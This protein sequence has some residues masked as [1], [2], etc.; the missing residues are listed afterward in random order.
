VRAL[1]VA[2]GF[3][4][5]ATPAASA[6]LH[7]K[8]AYVHAKK[9]VIVSL[10]SPV[11]QPIAVSETGPPHWSGDGRLLSIGGYVVGR[12][13]LPAA[14]LVWAPTGERAAYVT[15]QGGAGVWTPGSGRR[16]V[17]ANGWGAQSAAW[18]N[19]GSLAL[20]RAVCRAACGRPSHREVWVWRRGSLRRIVG[21]LVGDQTPMPF[22]WS[23]GRVLWWN[24]P[25]SGS[26]AADGVAL[27]ANARQIADALMYR[28]YVDACGTHL[29]IAAGGDRYAMHGKRILFDG[30][31]ASRDPSRSWVSPSCTADGRLVAAASANTVPNLIGR[32]R[33]SIWQLLPL[34]KQLTRPPVGWTDETP[35]LLQDGSVLFVRTR[36]TSRKVNG[37]WITTQRGTL[38]LLRAGRLS[39]VA[40]IGFTANGVTTDGA[41]LN[42]YGHYAWPSMLAVWTP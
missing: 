37:Q 30:R 20:G 5:L 31:D 36:Q 23:R 19:D 8:I 41:M 3:A 40:S 16:E 28:D 26:V 21:A 11:R 12:V 35:S 18:S 17:V 15:K 4:A 38:E 9:A 39:K 13:R 22:A 25:D 24:W 42:Y 29:A 7:A 1:A 27:Y 33:R 10:G 32:E 6:A 34:R 2:L 14:E